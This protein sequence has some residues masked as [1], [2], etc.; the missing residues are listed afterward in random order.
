M[1][2]AARLARHADLVALTSLVQRYWE[3]ERIPGF[4][5]SRITALLRQ[6]LD[7]PE[8]GRCWLSEET[9]QPVAYLLAVYVFSLEHGG[10]M[11][12]IDEF[13]VLP[14][15]RSRGIGTLLLGEAQRDMAAAG[16]VR[17]QLQLATDNSRGRLFYERQGF[18]SRGYDLLDKP[19]QER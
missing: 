1:A 17:L 12:E 16:L 15:Q 13:F 8:R 14:E 7:H 9:D 4:E 2:T 10:M 18:Q 19:L 5:P 11:A 3:F 6:L